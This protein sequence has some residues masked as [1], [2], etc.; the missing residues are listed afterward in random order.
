MFT[1]L[2]TQRLV[3]ATFFNTLGKM[4]AGNQLTKWNPAE[5]QT[6]PNRLY[7]GLKLDEFLK[8]LKTGNIGH[9]ATFPRG[10]KFDLS[11]CNIGCQVMRGCPELLSFSPSIDTARLYGGHR[12]LLPANGIIIEMGLS[13]IFTDI[14]QQASFCPMMCDAEQKYIENM[15]ED[16]FERGSTST[17][18]V[19][20][21]AALASE[22][23]AV[24]DGAG[25]VNLKETIPIDL[26]VKTIYHIIGTGRSYLNLVPES[27]CL[28]EAFKN[29]NFVERAIAIKIVLPQTKEELEML[30]ASSRNVGIL[31]PGQRLVTAEDAKFI[32]KD[33]LFKQ[34]A[35]T[36]SPSGGTKIIS[37]VPDKAYGPDMLE[38]LRSLKSLEKDFEA[39]HETKKSE[40]PSAK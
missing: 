32:M 9:H 19:A 22:I 4:V 17:V 40:G 16:R 10:Y 20:D 36:P 18:L 13:A 30:E 3:N 39:L 29:P 26:F 2:V 25:D 6:E 28:V 15:D 37:S 23:C 24:V 1:R 27:S 38:H 7:R 8:I 31:L 21:R 34:L 11:L 12:E 14:S 35:M 33:P 5:I